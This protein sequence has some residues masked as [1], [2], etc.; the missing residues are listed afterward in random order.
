MTFIIGWKEKN[1]VFIGGDIAISR[2]RK[3]N[4]SN[5][6]SIFGDKLIN[7]TAKSI[8]EECYKIFEINEKMIIAFSGNVQP[9]LEFI[10]NL[11]KYIDKDEIYKSLKNITD[12]TDAIKHEFTCIMGL[13]YPDGKNRLVSFNLY[14][15]NQ[16]RNH[17]KPISSGSLNSCYRK[18]SIT[19]CNKIASNR[20]LNN[21]EILTT[22]VAHHQSLIIR[23]KL[24]DQ[25]VGGTFVGCF[26]D[27]K[28]IWQKDTTL[29]LF[30]I[31]P[32]EEETESIDPHK[33][34]TKTMVVAYQIR[35]KIIR[36]ATP[37][38]SDS[39][40]RRNIYNCFQ[41]PRS[42]KDFIN[43]KDLIVGWFE[44][45]YEETNSNFESGK[46]DF[47]VTICR[48]KKFPPR[49]CVISKEFLIQNN[50]EISATGNGEFEFK[51]HK[52]YFIQIK[53]K[54]SQF[55]FNSRLWFK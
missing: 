55:A 36:L 8:N 43:N 3:L 12:R 17:E 9:A 10:D 16:L 44:N 4:L 23:N 29:L 45:H 33:V 20:N 32:G 47:Y 26:L 46:S 39:E 5:D 52:D 37:F 42:D 13:K 35:N 38:G 22:V 24:I 30:D 48:S 41:I 14:N 25:G 34:F 6:V 31:T 28:P 50:W 54:K 2:K 7:R 18:L 49:V 40:A 15:D 11:K 53:P 1:T 19:I 21:H 27:E 51:I